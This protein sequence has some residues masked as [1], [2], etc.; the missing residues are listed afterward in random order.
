MAVKSKVVI[1]KGKVRF[2]LDD[3]WVVN[4]AYNIKLD[5][6]LKTIWPV[7]Y[8]KNTVHYDRIVPSLGGEGYSD[9]MDK[10][11]YLVDK[12]EL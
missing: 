11:Q 7:G 12:G 5:E 1:V 6:D 3:D 9:I 2:L 8:K 10:A 4:G